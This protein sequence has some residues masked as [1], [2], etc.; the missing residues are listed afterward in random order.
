LADI[1]SNVTINAGSGATVAFTNGVLTSHG[2]TLSGVNNG[3]ATN[4]ATDT[5]PDGLGTGAEVGIS[6]AF[7]ITL[8]PGPPV[9]ILASAPGP[10]VEADVPAASC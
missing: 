7:V 1:T 4:T 8:P 3:A 2:V 10:A 5:D 9:I 6:A